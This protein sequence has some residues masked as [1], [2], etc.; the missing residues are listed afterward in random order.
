MSDYLIS[1]IP[2]SATH[3]LA[4][5]ALMYLIWW[6]LKF[7]QPQ[8][9]ISAKTP[10]ILGVG[11][12]LLFTLGTV[13]SVIQNQAIINRMKEKTK[14]PFDGLPPGE[15]AQK[16]H[17]IKSSFLSTVENLIANPVQLTESSKQALFE[18]FKVLFPHGK[19]D[20]SVYG[21]QIAQ[22]YSCQ[23]I[24]YEDA[25]QA[26]KT[27]KAVKSEGRQNCQSLK[28]DFFGRVLLVPEDVARANDETIASVASNKKLIQN[29][30]EIKIDEGYFR[31]GRE[32]QTRKLQT[33]SLLFE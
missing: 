12:S 17:Q 8:W 14:V 4:C 11:L 28:G 25:L 32:E 9:V 31:Q 27:K 15:A 20:R 1:L 30:Q 24:F 23:K 19:E 13:T 18:Q 10:I 26:L 22:V 2:S 29:G 16:I 3:M 7:A 21:D 5:I 33:L 6:I